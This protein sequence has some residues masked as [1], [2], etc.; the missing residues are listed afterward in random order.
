MLSQFFEADWKMKIAVRMP[1]TPVNAKAT[2]GKGV[3][4][5]KFCNTKIIVDFTSAYILLIFTST[6]W[7][8]LCM[9]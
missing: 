9:C 4:S 6:S 8:H 1:T 2:V 5:P 3:V 7:L